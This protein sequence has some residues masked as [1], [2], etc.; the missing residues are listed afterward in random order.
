VNEWPAD[1]VE[2]RKVLDLTP[3]ARNARTHSDEQ[4]AQIAASIREWGWTV[5][6]L[7]DERGEIIAGHGRVLAAQRLGL[8]DVPC[9]VAEGWTEAQRRAYVLADNKLTLNGGW[10]DE[11]LRV[12]L[13]DLDA[14]GFDLEK[15]GFGIGELSAI[16]DT[17]DF[18]PGTEDDQGKLD[19]LAPKMVTCPHCGG[20]WDLREHGQG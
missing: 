19:E 16:F 9:M 15:T 4:V 12:E 7:V 6:I 10:N 3:Y 1:K 20:E 18:A 14:M 11:L 5:P 13:Q 2:R 8:V 17:P